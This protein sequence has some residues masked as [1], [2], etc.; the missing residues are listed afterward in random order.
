MFSK[1]GLP[2]N[3]LEFKLIWVTELEIIKQWVIPHQLIEQL[4]HH[5]T[6]KRCSAQCYYPC[7]QFPHFDR[8]KSAFVVFMSLDSN[9]LRLFIQ[10]HRSQIQL[11]LG[12]WECFHSSSSEDFCQSTPNAVFYVFCYFSSS[13]T[14]FGQLHSKLSVDKRHL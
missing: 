13:A 7:L 5:I 1:I 12:I 4:T 14:F 2:F 6:E 9:I 10:I 3:F 11:W 8:Y